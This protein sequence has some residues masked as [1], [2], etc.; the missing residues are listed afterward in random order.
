MHNKLRYRCDV[1]QI[2]DGELD[3]E[4]VMQEVLKDLAEKSANAETQ[5]VKEAIKAC[6]QKSKLQ[7]LKLD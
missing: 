3:Q 6:A 4:M 5:K 2:K 1:L 7:S